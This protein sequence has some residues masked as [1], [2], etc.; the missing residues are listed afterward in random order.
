MVS[1]R[2]FCSARFA[3]SAAASSPGSARTAEDAA[4]S[5]ASAHA[6]REEDAGGAAAEVWADDAFVF[7]WERAEGARAGTGLR[8]GA[9]TRVGAGR[10]GR[11]PAPA[12]RVHARVLERLLVLLGFLARGGWRSRRARQGHGLLGERIVVLESVVRGG[13]GRAGRGAPRVAR[14]GSGRRSHRTGR[15]RRRR[16]RRQRGHLIEESLVVLRVEGGEGRLKSQRTG[17]EGRR[18]A[19]GETNLVGSGDVALGRDSGTVR[20]APRERRGEV[21]AKGREDVVVVVIRCVRGVRHVSEPDKSRIL[22]P[23]R[24]ES[25]T[26]PKRPTRYKESA[27]S[28]IVSRRAGAVVPPSV[29]RG[30]CAEQRGSRATTALSKSRETLP[31]G[32]NFLGQTDRC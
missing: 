6:G 23:R 22:K 24:G 1:F 28:A 2:L 7:E 14:G 19:R 18:E 8:R 4:P 27:F 5:G 15:R 26:T 29:L 11:G 16:R 31:F 21:P 3:A 17:R 13:V 25:L 12:P 20:R 10:G 30:S 9:W 32:G